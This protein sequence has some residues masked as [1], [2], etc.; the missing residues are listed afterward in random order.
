MISL[1]LTDLYQNF[2]FVLNKV[3]ITLDIRVNR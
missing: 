2:I 1:I 3:G